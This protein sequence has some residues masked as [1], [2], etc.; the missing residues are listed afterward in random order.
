MKN[1]EADEVGSK[2]G[3][4]DG[5]LDAAAIEKACVLA[6]DHGEKRIGLAFKPEASS[7]VLPIGVVEVGGESSAFETIRRE[8]AERG[9]RIVVVGLPVH[10]DG[11]QAQRVK[12][13]T[14]KLR[15]GVT[16]VRWRF[17]DESFTSEAADARLREADLAG[18]GT[19]NDAIAA[20]L[21]LESFIH[22]LSESDDGQP[23]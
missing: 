5:G 15:K 12:R 9:A 6:V 19:P 11:R 10:P 3:P 2:A 18:A 17:V 22:R 13:F 20:C 21:I 7:M 1:H 16:G 8:I 23:G 14:R 4:V